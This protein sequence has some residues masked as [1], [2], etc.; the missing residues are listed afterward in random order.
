MVTVYDADAAKTIEKLAQALKTHI[1]APEWTKFVKTGMAKERQPTAQ[2]WFYT[3]AASV[4]RTVY[5]RGP[6]GVQKLRVKYG[7]KKNRG[8][9]PERF[10]KGSGKILRNV[11]QQLEKASLVKFQKESVHKGRIITAKG[12]SLVD[13]SAV[14]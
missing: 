8:H 12:K 10:Y 6:I 1:Q 3:R 4:L 13:K 7:S 14:K 5:M 9:N 2:D 11:L